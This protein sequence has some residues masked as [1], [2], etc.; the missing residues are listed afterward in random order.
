[1]E[2][3]IDFTF[4]FIKE[5]LLI[6]VMLI[7][8]Y[9][10]AV[11]SKFSHYNVINFAPWLHAAQIRNGLNPDSSK[12]FYLWGFHDFA[13]IAFEV[14]DEAH[15]AG[16]AHA[17]FVFEAAGAEQHGAVLDVVEEA[18]VQ[19][20]AR[21][22]CTRSS[23]ARIAVD[24]HDVL[25]VFLKPL[26]HLVDEVEENVERRRM[27]VLPAE[28]GH[29]VVESGCVVGPLADVEDVI[30]ARV[31][32]VHEFLDL[33]IAIIW[34]AKSKSRGS[35]YVLNIIPPI[36]GESRSRKT[37]DD[38][39]VG[40]YVSQIDV[41]LICGISPSLSWNHTFDKVCLHLVFLLIN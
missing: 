37:H 13:I 18:D 9:L 39:P 11:E 7:V 29:A 23:F 21:A 15:L 25:R 10:F 4:Q 24:R 14:V 30:L 36:T 27:V 19:K 20:E 3:Q 41:M 35:T 31:L 40:A 28:V 22:S 6:L 2:R 5:S 17:L 8:K 32:L 16:L 12:I 33:K 26:V 34:D 1:M 38:N